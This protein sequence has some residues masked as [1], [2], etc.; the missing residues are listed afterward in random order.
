MTFGLVRVD[1]D[2]RHATRRVVGIKLVVAVLAAEHERTV[3]TREHDHQQL[4]ILEVGE[5]IVLAVHAGQV[6][7]G[8]FCANL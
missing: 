2:H 1:R 4:C 7:I 5:R 3:I 6:K 8:G